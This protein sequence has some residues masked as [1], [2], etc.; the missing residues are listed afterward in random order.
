[1]KLNGKT[2]AGA[3]EAFIIIPREV[4]ED[5][6]FKARAVTDAEDF[7][8]MCPE[9]DPPVRVFPNG[10]EVLNVKDPG[11]LD[12]V[13]NHAT[14]RLSWLVLTSLSATEDLVWE[15][16]DITDVTTWNNFRIELS[17][18]GFSTVEVNRIVSECLAVNSLNEEKLQAARER[19]LLKAQVQD[20]E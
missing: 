8:K 18:A 20:D 3:N 4:G 5:I 17:E 9:P 1:M 6:V 13:K 11:Y 15:K 19:F 10:Q 14:L 2:I 12:Q 7:D 16:V